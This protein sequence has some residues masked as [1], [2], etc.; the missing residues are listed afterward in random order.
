[1]TRIALATVLSL[2]L[3]TAASAGENLLEN[4][5]FDAGLPGWRPA[6]SRTPTARAAPDRAAKH[7]GAASVRIEHTGTQDWSFGVER[8]VD[9]RPGQIYELSGWVRVEGQGNAVLGVILR[10]AKGEAMDW[11][12]G[13]RVTRATKGWRRLHSRFVIP[14]GATRIEPRL[15]GHGPATAWLDDAILTLEGTMDDLRA[16]ELPETLA[17]SNAALEVV[18]RCADATLTV[19]DKRTGHTW[20]QRAGSTSCVVADAKAVEGGLDLKLVHAAG[21]LTLDAR[22]RLDAQRPEF[23]VEL[24]GKGEMPDTIAFPAP[25]VTGKGTFLVL[26]VNEGI[27]YPVDDPTLRPMHYYLYGGHGLCMP[28]WGATD[29]DRGV[30]AIVETA[31]DAAVRVPRLDGLLC[32][33]PQWQPQK[34]RFGPARVIRYAFFDKGGYVAMAKRYRAHAKATGLLKT[35]AEKRQANP[36]VDL[37]VGAVN[38][39]CWERDA[40]KWCREMQQLGI[41]RIL[42]SNRRPPDELKA[43][44][45]LGVLSSRYDIYQDSMDPK[46]FPRLRGKHGDWTSEA[47]ANDHIMHDANGD[48]VRGWR[49]KAKD[50]EMIPCGVLC[51]R[52]APAYARRRIPAE[53]KTHPYRC[54]FIDTTTASPWRECYHPKHP[55]TRTESKRF[56]MELLKVVSEENGLVCGSETGHDAAV[57]VVHYFEGMLSLGPYR[58]P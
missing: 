48:W 7:G 44:N 37:L 55:M 46:F 29:G 12:Y 6:W 2:A 49:V 23:T 22:L 24:A 13:A 58:V 14:P 50:G 42:W 57:P 25:F 8:L 43:L 16:K 56:K 30:M 15:I 17:T 41:G 31:D 19:R 52:E 4:G 21:M 20:T 51:D 34:G 26:P 45:D 39:W 5:T 36:H 33:A 47:W 35:L 28:W 54:R 9:V 10:D 3:A 18:L 32:L 11:A 38:V 27:S 53:L 40:P 1:M